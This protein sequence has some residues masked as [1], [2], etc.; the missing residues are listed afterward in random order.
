MR[1]SLVFFCV[2]RKQVVEFYEKMDG[3][4]DSNKVKYTKARFF[5][6]DGV[7][8]KIARNDEA[9]IG[10]LAGYMAVVFSFRYIL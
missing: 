9:L 2:V 4:L 5:A 1:L 8:L 10:Q 6:E 7:T 3:K